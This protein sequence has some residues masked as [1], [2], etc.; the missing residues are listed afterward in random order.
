MELVKDEIWHGFTAITTLQSFNDSILEQ[1]CFKDEVAE[2]IKEGGLQVQKLLLHS[3]YEYSFIEIA[4][5]QAIFLL[6]KALSAR[7]KEIHGERPKENFEKLIDWFFDNN[8]FET[9]DVQRIHGLRKLR[10]KK[11]HRLNNGIGGVAIIHNVYWI[12]DLINGLYESPELRR[13]RMES[14]YGLIDQFGK[15]V[16]NGVVLSMHGKKYLAFS[17]S[18]VFINNKSEPATLHLFVSLIFDLQLQLDGK[19]HYSTVKLSVS[20]WRFD[21]NNF[22]ATDLSDGK[23]MMVSKITDK[24]NRDKFDAWQVGFNQLP[25]FS[26]LLFE[27]FE[28]ITKLQTNYL[29]ALHKD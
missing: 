2:E 12:F 13:V 6:D 22:K 11:V 7:W 27:I 15:F 25:D 21:G 14:Y 29:R 23:P 16:R 9:V 1:V 24:I 3:Y 28:P 5:T 20:D 26:L 10:N 4:I 18:P 8:Y 17:V 19:I